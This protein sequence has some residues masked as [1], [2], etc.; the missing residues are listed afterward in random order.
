MMCGCKCSVWCTALSCTLSRYVF[1]LIVASWKNNRPVSRLRIEPHNKLTFG[2][3]RMWPPNNVEI[4]IT[5]DFDTVSVNSTCDVECSLG[6]EHNNTIFSW[7]QHHSHC[8]WASLLRNVEAACPHQVP[9]AALVESLY[10][11][12]LKCYV[13]N[14]HGSTWNS[15]HAQSSSYGFFT[16]KCNRFFKPLHI[17]ADAWPDTSWKI[18]GT[19]GF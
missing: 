3:P 12:N 13:A 1:V 19:T 7:S 16:V 8:E 10:V 18:I 4:I 5:P 9:I 2:L 6:R 11:L 17:I 15:Q 14:I